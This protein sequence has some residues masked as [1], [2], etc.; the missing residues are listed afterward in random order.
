MKKTTCKICGQVV[1]GYSQQ[2][3]DFLMMQHMLKH[4]H[5]GGKK[6]EDE[7]NND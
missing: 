7:N 6:E 4:R 3:A 1:E 2:H 5:K